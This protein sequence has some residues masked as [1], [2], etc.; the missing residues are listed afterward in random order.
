MLSSWNYRLQRVYC[1]IE[2]LLDFPVWPE[3]SH[4]PSTVGPATQLIL[5]FLWNRSIKITL[6]PGAVKRDYVKMQTHIVHS[7]RF[8]RLAPFSPEA[9][10]QMG[11]NFFFPSIPVVLRYWS[12]SIRVYIWVYLRM[13]LWEA[14]WNFTIQYLWKQNQRPIL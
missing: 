4:L 7:V 5:R 6:E 1:L 14:K 3:D 10:C 12:V 11:N 13:D 2:V 8:M 9:S